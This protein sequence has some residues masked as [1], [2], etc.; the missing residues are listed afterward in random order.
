MSWTGNGERGTADHKGGRLFQGIGCE[1]EERHGVGVKRNKRWREG[2]F[3]VGKMAAHVK[4]C[5]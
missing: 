4:F 1:R 2:T 3:K 5:W